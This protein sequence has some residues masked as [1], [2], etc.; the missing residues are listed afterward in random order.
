MRVLLNSHHAISRHALH[1]LSAVFHL[2][3]Q[4]DA[5]FSAFRECARE[6][7]INTNLLVTTG[8]QCAAGGG[9]EGGDAPCTLRSRLVIDLLPF[10]GP[11]PDRT[12]C[13][14]NIHTDEIGVID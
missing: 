6:R 13:A 1:L 14:S 12:M 9:G 11:G 4:V 3:Q 2:L 8:D 10:S 7:E 5:G